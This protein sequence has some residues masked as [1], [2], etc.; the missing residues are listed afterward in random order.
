MSEQ[1]F[2]SASLGS[3]QGV[4]IDGDSDPGTTG[5][6]SATDGNRIVSCIGCEDM[7]GVYWQWGRDRGSNDASSWSDAY[8]SSD[9][10]VAGEHYSDTRVARFG[11]DWDDGSNCGSRGSHWNN[12]P[13]YLHSFSSSRA[14]SVSRSRGD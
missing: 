3:P 5:G 2:Q 14:V 8:N 9:I 11:G 13:L 6:H 1:E 7:C 10:N 12:G 4:N